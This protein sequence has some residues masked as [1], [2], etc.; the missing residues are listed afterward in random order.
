MAFL[1]G[2]H[3]GSYRVSTGRAHPKRVPLYDYSGIALTEAATENERDPRDFMLVG[4]DPVIGHLRDAED[5]LLY[6]VTV[7]LTLWWSRSV[8]VP[9]G[10]QL[11]EQVTVG[12]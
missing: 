12:P 10:D 7:D 6:V 11:V 9:F 8:S 2:T 4:D 5:D 3:S 1:R